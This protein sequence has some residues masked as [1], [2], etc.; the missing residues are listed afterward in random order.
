MSRILFIFGSG[1]HATRGQILSRQMTEY[2]QFFMVPWES[3]VAKARAGENQYSVLSPRFRAKDNQIMTIFRTVFLFI[4]SLIIIIITRPGVVVSTG[5]GITMPPFLIASL[6]KIPTIY[7]ESPSRVYEPSLAGRF[8]MN[9]TTLWF[10]SWKEMQ[11][12]YDVTYG[13]IIR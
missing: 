5:S 2:D 4:H 3:N 9:K 7:F 11:E 10:S 8:L 12:R 1:G 6:L 13:G